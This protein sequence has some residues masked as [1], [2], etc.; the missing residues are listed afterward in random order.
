[1][2]DLIQVPRTVYFAPTR[3]RSY[4]TKSGAA[5]A[6]AGALLSAKYPTQRP[7][8]DTDG[9]CYCAGWHWSEDDKLRL[10]H[11]RLVQRLLR[12]AR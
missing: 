10:V 6:E 11:S 7:E 2:G 3:K 4:L 8:Y 9:R 5:K 1:M 12:R